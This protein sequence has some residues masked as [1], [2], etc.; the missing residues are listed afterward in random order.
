MIEA[1]PAVTWSVEGGLATVRMSRR[2]GNAI[3]ETLVHGLSSVFREIQG[4]ASVRGAL[5]SARGKLFCPGLDLQELVEYDRGSM[6]AFLGRFGDC[7]VAMFTFPK[8]ML[9]ALSGHALA[10]GCILA[11]TA[12]WRVLRRGAL[13]GLNEIRVGV[14]LPY[15]VAQLLRASVHPNRLEE[16]ALLGRNYTDQAAVDT[17]LVHEIAD[18]EGFEELCRARLQ[19]FASKDAAAFSRTKSYLRSATM[20]RFLAGDAAKKDEFLDCWF[21]DATRGRIRD[22]VADLKGRSR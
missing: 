13:V 19:E 5:L 9:A 21:A 15:G 14:P 11:L 20:E 10:G 1:T 22:V 7:L 8:P 17:G 16:V 4:D 6:A 3:D 2:H 12:D 18:A